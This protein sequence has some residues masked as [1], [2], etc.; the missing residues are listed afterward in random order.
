MLHGE[1][2]G[3]ASLCWNFN[4]GRSHQDK[5]IEFD[6]VLNVDEMKEWKSEKWT[7]DE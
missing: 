1:G 3:G 7:N 4:E 6:S 5:L 2:A